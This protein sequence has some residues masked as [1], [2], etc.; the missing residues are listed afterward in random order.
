MIYSGM[1]IKIKIGVILPVTIEICSAFFTYII[2]ST[3]YL[4]S[5]K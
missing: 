3:W 2:L 4:L 5:I 1:D